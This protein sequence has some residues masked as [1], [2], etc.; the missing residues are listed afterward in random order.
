MPAQDN[1][2]SYFGDIDESQY[3]TYSKI[4]EILALSQ[5]E[6]G[7]N[8]ISIEHQR[9]NLSKEANRNISKI[10]DLLRIIDLRINADAVSGQRSLYRTQYDLYQGKLTNLKIQLRQAQLKSY[11]L[12]NELVHK[13]RVEKFVKTYESAKTEGTKEDLFSGRSVNKDDANKNSKTVED[14]ILSHNKNITSTLQATRNLMNTSIVQ[15]ELNIESLDAQTKDLS[16]LNDKLIDLSVVINRSRQVVKFIEKQDREDKRRI[17]L[18]LGFF[19][20]CCAWVVWRRILKLPV[21]IM[22]WTFFKLFGI[23]SWAASKNTE[24]KVAVASLTALG[25]ASALA[26]AVSSAVSEFTTDIIQEISDSEPLTWD[27]IIEHTT[28]LVLD[29]L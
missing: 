19:A 27:G 7:Q 2:K 20:L 14:Q 5:Q 11:S 17:Y 6:L 3:A 1:I 16:Q 22:L 24:V 21:K 10:R 28:S 29:E 26:T 4:A 25:L 12:E 23:F 18:S 8:E 13:Q 9:I 15:T